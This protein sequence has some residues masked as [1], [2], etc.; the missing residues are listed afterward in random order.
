MSICILEQEY[1]IESTTILDLSHKKLTEF[2]ESILMFTN[3]QFLYL[4][5]NNLANLSESIGTL[6]NKNFS[7]YLISYL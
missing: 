3:L 6:S 2:P 4:H 1:D 7:F 5:N